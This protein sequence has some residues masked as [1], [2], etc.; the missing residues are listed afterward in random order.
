MS[1]QSYLSRPAAS[2]MPLMP[3]LSNARSLSRAAMLSAAFAAAGVGAT[4]PKCVGRLSNSCSIGSMALV[5]H[6]KEGAVG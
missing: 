5:N 4:L 1:H 6:C 3:P 2:L